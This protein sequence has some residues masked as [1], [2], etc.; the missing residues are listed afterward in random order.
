MTL[1]HVQMSRFII[2]LTYSGLALDTGELKRK[3][4]EKAC[5]TIKDN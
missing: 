3:V 2:S 1:T 5:K 4:Q